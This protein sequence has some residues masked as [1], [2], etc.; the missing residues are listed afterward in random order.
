ALP[1]PN[2]HRPDLNH[3][4][5]APRTT[6]ERTLASVW[7]DILGITTIGI[8][9]NFFELGGHSLL[10]TQVTSRLRQQLGIDVPVRTLFTSPTPATLAAAMREL[11]T[12]DE[13]PLVPVDRAD[14]SLPLSFA[15]QRLWFLD[16]LT[17]GSAEYLVPFGLRV[18]GELNAGA[19][20]TAFTALVARHEILRTRFVTD[21]SGRPSQI[22]EAPWSVTP[23]VHDVRAVATPADRERT[24]Q[25]IMGAEARRPFELDGGRLLRVDLVRV[26]EDDQ[27]LLVTLHHIVSD[28]WSSGIL[29]RELRELYAAALAEREVS[30]PELPVQ[31]ADFA[32]W[33]RDR[34]TG[35]FLD[36]QLT[37]WRERLAGVPVLEL[38]TD[39]VRPPEREGAAGDT[40]HFTLPAEVAEQLRSTAGRQGASLF[41]TLLSLFQV[42]LARY[43]RQDD[44]AVGTPIAGRNR[45]ETEDL[46]GFFVNTLVMRTDLSGDPTFAEL[47]N[48]VKDT[49]LG[50]YDHQDLPFERL[51]DELAPNRDLS[52]NPLFQTLFVFQN[53]PDGDTWSLP[54]LD[55][56]QVGVGGQDAKFDLQLTA[57]ESG[58]EVLAALEYRTDLFDRARIERMAGHLST[59][60]ASVA[61]TP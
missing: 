4:Y 32:V 45:A 19:L 61:A 6:T 55:V 53:T 58:G 57:A 11:A 22:V 34:L 49:A 23:V 13:A 40:V 33:Q 47:I 8:H 35:E 30:L 16:Q 24:A 5:T 9:D 60:A 18:R 46:I 44:I 10:A 52:R 1:T 31:Y 42:V 56:E 2:H 54:G 37:Y 39:H 26:A 12:A 27:Y 50:A 28:G 20:G 7:S 17:P 38:P 29:A 25:E 3:T 21:D 15:Q 51:V 59:L 41:M 14:G 43:G 48:R 36:E